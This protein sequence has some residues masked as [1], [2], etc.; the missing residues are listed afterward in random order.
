[1][2]AVPQDISFPGGGEVSYV[3]IKDCSL[4][5]LED[6]DTGESPYL[7]KAVY[8]GPSS[9]YIRL[10]SNE[11]YGVVNFGNVGGYTRRPDAIGNKFHSGNLAGRSF[12]SLVNSNFFVDAPTRF[13]LYP[14]RHNHIRFNEVHQASR[15]VW[16]N[17]EEIFLVRGGSHKSGGYATEASAT[18]LVDRTKNWKPHQY[19]D[20]VVLII[21]GRGFGQYRVVTDSTSDT[22]TLESPL[23]VIP[24]TTS[25]YVVGGMYL[26]ND[27]YANLNNTPCR[28]SL[29]LDCIAN[30]VELHRDVFAKGSDIWGQDRTSV[31]E[32]SIAENPEHFYPSYYNIIA[33]CW[34]D[35]SY[36][37]IV[38]G[39]STR[40]I[41]R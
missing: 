39:V 32:Q 2:E 24:D 5:A 21:S 11:I 3:T 34:M 37:N 7:T 4:R 8:I 29:W 28:L 19:K 40:N 16:T 27:F 9:R 10:I 41:Y 30:V 18:T 35:G 26:E 17:A 14:V 6:M 13:L 1:M 22:L 38:S 33:N 25:E 20:A 31:D 36:F 12:D 15:N 23:R